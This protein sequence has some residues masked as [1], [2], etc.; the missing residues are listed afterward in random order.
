MPL[1]IAALTAFVASIL[2]KLLADHFLSA[3]IS[4]LGP[5]LSLTYTENLGIA[6]GIRF[7]PMMQSLLILLSL[8]LVVF[9]AYRSKGSR[10][11]QIAF[12]LII[13]GACGNLLDRALDGLVTD[14]IRVGSFPIFNI[15]DSCITIGAFL[16]L[17]DL[18]FLQSRHTKTS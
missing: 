10:L 5:F 2:G 16:L 12:G 14:F 17:A 11:Q 7:P 9:L 6:F 15:A 3:P 4:L 1:R 8:C 13:G 18:L